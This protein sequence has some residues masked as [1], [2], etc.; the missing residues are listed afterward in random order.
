MGVGHPLMAKALQQAKRLHGV[1]CVVEG[2]TAPLQI[3]GV[4]NRV[5]GATGS[6]RRLIFGVSGRSENLV[7]LK[8]W[9]VLRALALCLLKPEP[10]AE[11][12]GRAKDVGAWLTHANSMTTIL[13]EGEALPFASMHIVQI[14]MLWPGD[15]HLESTI[16][17]RLSAMEPPNRTSSNG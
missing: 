2:L 13:L 5:T 7:L 16:E 3:I 14:A 15:V 11:L 6:S 10:A 4:S 1:F 9:Q 12:P 17:D 8:D